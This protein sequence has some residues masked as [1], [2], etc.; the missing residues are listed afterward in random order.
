V[1]LFTTPQV[2]I[3]ATPLVLEAYSFL[4]PP[5]V[6]LHPSGTSEIEAIRLLRDYRNPMS[7]LASTS[8]Q[9]AYTDWQQGMFGSNEQWEAY[10]QTLYH[11]NADV[12]REIIER[13][14]VRATM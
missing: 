8:V 6:I 5:A 3:L 2:P 10:H 11:A 9:L 7:L 14:N 1:L 12:L 13:D 4:R